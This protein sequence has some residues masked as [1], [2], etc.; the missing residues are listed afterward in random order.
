MSKRKYGYEDD[1]L[2][3]EKEVDQNTSKLKD[4][5]DAYFAKNGEVKQLFVDQIITSTYVPQ[6]NLSKYFAFDVG[7]RDL[8]Y[9][10][11]KP[12]ETRYMANMVEGSSI[13]VIIT[14]VDKRSSMI[15]GSVASLYENNA[16]RDIIDNVD[17]VI[18]EGVIREIVPAG[19][20]VDIEFNGLPLRGFMP[21]TQAGANKLLDPNSIVGMKMEV[22]VESFSQKD[23]IYV[24]S[25]KK[26][27]Q[28]LA[29]AQI[30]KL[31]TRT[32]YNGIVTGTTDFGVFVEFNECLTGMIH[33]TNVNTEWQERIH[34]IL[35]GFE[36][37]FYVKQIQKDGRIILT[38]MRE[39]ALIETL[40][41]GMT[42]EGTVKSITNGVITISLDD[43]TTGVLH[44]SEVTKLNNPVAVG[45]VL[46]V[47]VFSVDLDKDR[48][49]LLL[50][51]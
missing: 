31:N 40:E 49:N 46:P 28:T 39:L 2:V 33:K 50:N 7:N 21:N 15:E 14:G 32:V 23:K 6:Y 35:P 48:I 34:D 30:K 37:D 26:Y 47:K 10:E 19:Y 9:V 4:A 5:F 12:S 8:L 1:F 27:L 16:H 22:M 17:T 44:F 20:N 29:P 43:E 13:D 38:Q 36:V 3:A 51:C 24:V 42:L 11:N 41:M 18:L 45:D 25:R